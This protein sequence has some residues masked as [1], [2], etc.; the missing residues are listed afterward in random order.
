MG[1]SKQGAASP[2]APKEP[3]TKAM[4]ISGDT[5][6]FMAH[7]ARMPGGGAGQR[8]LEFGAPALSLAAAGQEQ[9]HAIWTG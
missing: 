4:S 6:W 5:H 9:V 2:E 1:K 3:T 8:A 7:T